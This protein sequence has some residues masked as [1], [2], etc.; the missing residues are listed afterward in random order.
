MNIA[1]KLATGIIA[2]GLATAGLVAATPASATVYNV[3]CPTGGV[4]IDSNNN[5]SYCYDWDGTT[6]GNNNIGWMD[7]PNTKQ[8]CSGA[9]DGYV[10]DVSGAVHPFYHGGCVATGGAHLQYIVFNS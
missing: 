9:N 4:R 10:L 7:L 5:P 8:I 3:S 1:R 6:G 2:A